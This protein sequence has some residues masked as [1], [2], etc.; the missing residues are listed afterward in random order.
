[1]AKPRQELSLTRGGAAALLH[2]TM[3]HYSAALH[4]YVAHYDT[5]LH[6]YVAHYGTHYMAMLPTTRCH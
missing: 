6:G 1:M 3:Q 2:R 4:G 5:A